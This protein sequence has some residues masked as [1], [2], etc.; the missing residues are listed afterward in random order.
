LPKF[1]SENA[2][3]TVCEFHTRKNLKV[4]SVINVSNLT[5][6]FK[7]AVKNPGFLGTISSIFTPSYR[8]IKAVDKISFKVKA[9]ELVGFI[10]PNGA[11]KTTTLKILSGLLHPSEGEVSV[12][13]FTP[14]Q[15]K[16][17]FQKQFALVAG[18]KNQLWWDLPSYDCFLLN[19]E[20][21]GVPNSVFK[22]TLTELVDLLD[23]GKLLKTPVR[24]LSLG[25][26]MKAELVAAL[27]H[28]P[29]VLFLDEP[30]IGL[31]LVVAK[32]LR[33][34]IKNYA[35]TGATI[36]LTSHNMGDIKELCQRIIIINLGKIIY[37]G[38]LDEIVAA[39]ADHKVISLVFEKPV[40]AEKLKKFGK[41]ENFNTLLASIE[42]E[43]TEIS[44]IAAEILSN[45][46]VADLT[47]EEPPIEEIIRKIFTKKN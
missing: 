24:K 33:D 35:K 2:R 43:R 29:K 4:D 20:I 21:Y 31:D 28:S 30:T 47:I 17:Q 11:G 22:K 9:G 1:F 13:G 3:Q 42:V 23:L 7:V 5:K 6:T 41:I 19:K 40:E 39:Y 16:T 18:Q 34:F 26:R 8:E 10:G 38:A 25:E 45:F 12:L 46:P 27:L 15:R 44:T 14:W 36:I 32:K 37:D